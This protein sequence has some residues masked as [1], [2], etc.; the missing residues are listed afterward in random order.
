MTKEESEEL[1][2]SSEATRKRAVLV[3][4]AD[5]YARVEKKRQKLADGR[6]VNLRDAVGRLPR[7]RTRD[8]GNSEFVAT[9]RS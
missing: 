8:R 9:V 4:V 7:P 5:H 3:R 1:T 6:P 2:R